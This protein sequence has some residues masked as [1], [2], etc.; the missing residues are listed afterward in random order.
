[1]R[2]LAALIIL[3]FLAVGMTPSRADANFWEWLDSL[4]G[5]RFG[6]LALELQLACRVKNVA[7]SAGARE[8]IGRRLDAEQL[9]YEQAAKTY[10]REARPFAE[11]AVRYRAVA[12]RF[13]ELANAEKAKDPRA[14]VTSAVLDALAWQARAAEHFAWAERVEFERIL[15]PR[16][17]PGS[18]DADADRVDFTRRMLPVS[19]VKYS[20][21]D[22]RPL[23]R[24][25]HVLNASVTFGLDI[26][27]DDGDAPGRHKMLTFGASYHK[28]LQPW[29]TVGAGAGVATFFPSG[30]DTF[31]KLYVQPYIVDV[32][33]W[34]FGRDADV[35]SPWRHFVYVRYS[36]ITFPQGF[37]AGRF[38]RGSE[39]YPKEMVH[40]LGVHFDLTPVLRGRRGNY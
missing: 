3:A 38:W 29:L 33:P 22:Y 31:S 2:R 13:L 11:S 16:K 34:A 14:D 26:K 25:D 32:K 1:M 5:P 15:D 20:F 18:Y 19:G 24:D 36:T 10:G 6:G 7:D 4:S 28:V 12:E 35:G 9:V 30:A 21:C 17:K 8:A 27:N 39:R 40:S 37:E 23:D